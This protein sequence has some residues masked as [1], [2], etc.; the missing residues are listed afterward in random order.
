MNK[1]LCI[2]VG[3]WNNSIFNLLIY[4]SLWHCQSEWYRDHT[5]HRYPVSGRIC[6]P[7]ESDELRSRLHLKPDGT[8][9]RTGGEVKGKLAN[10]VCSQ[11]SHTTSE[12]GVSSTTNADA[13]TSAASSRL[14]LRSRRFKWTRPFLR[15]K[16]SGFCAR[17]I[18]FQTQS[19]NVQFH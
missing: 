7:R 2:K 3:K 16:K 8:R 10:G 9:W 11:Y 1:E 17:A 19:T 12:H 13:H 14:N 18:T 15:K 4:W 6:F 5:V